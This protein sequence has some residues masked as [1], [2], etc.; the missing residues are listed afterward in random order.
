VSRFFALK[1]GLG[2]AAADLM[3]GQKLGPNWFGRWRDIG[4]FGHYVVILGDID[5]EIDQM[6]SFC[7]FGVKSLRHQG[8]RF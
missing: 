2:D 4:F 5:G 8:L 1:R 6:G 7:F 3:R